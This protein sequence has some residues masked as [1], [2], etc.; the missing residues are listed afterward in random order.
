M[1]IKTDFLVVFNDMQLIQIIKLKKWWFFLLEIMNVGA[2]A[3]I[4]K[5]KAIRLYK[6]LSLSIFFSLLYVVHKSK[7][8]KKS[9]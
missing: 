4:L 1:L 8:W 3:S 2:L 5:E 9:K 7:G 6:K